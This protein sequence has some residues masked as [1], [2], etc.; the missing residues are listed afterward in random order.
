VGDLSTLQQL[1]MQHV[2][3]PKV[4]WC[5]LLLLLLLRCQHR[6]ADCADTGYIN[7]QVYT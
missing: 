7:V 6:T 1:W 2:L 5:L 4:A 3:L